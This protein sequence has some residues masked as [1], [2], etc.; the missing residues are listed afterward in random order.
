M[1]LVKKFLFFFCRVGNLMTQEN[2]K[3]RDYTID[4]LIKEESESHDAKIQFYLS[5]KYQDKELYEESLEWAKKSAD[6][7]FADGIA[8]YA[9]H[10]YHGCGCKKDI[11]KAFELYTK[12]AEKGSILA[13]NNLAYTFNDEE[14]EGQDKAEAL[15]W[16]KK[17]AEAGSTDA[18]YNIGQMYYF[19]EEVSMDKLEAFKWYLLAANAGDADAQFKIGVMYDMGEGVSPDEKE[20]VAWLIRSAEQNCAHAQAM[21]GLMYEKGKGVQKNKEEARRLYKLAAD[22]G[23]FHGLEMLEA[24]DSFID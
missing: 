16:Y 15:K 1:Y 17:A 9:W 5:G 4:E 3:H 19:G 20:A 14:Y 7:N 18:Q 11:K 24:L 2:V 10:L 23:D 13:M 21:L 6:Q 12:A 8:R 22:Q